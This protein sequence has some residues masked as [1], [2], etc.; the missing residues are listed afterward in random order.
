MKNKRRL[1]DDIPG[2]HIIVENLASGKNEHWIVSI[3]FGTMD[4]FSIFDRIHDALIQH[5]VLKGF[6]R[7]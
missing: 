5:M 4:K 2:M 3:Q 7:L 6:R 1:K